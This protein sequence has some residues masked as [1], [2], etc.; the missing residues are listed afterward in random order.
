[1][2]TFVQA[3]YA[4]VTF[5][6]INNISA[7]TDPILTKFFGPNFG[8]PFL[9]QGIFIPKS[10]WP[11]FF[12]TRFSFDLN[13]FS[14]NFFWTKLLLTKVFFGPKFFWTRFFSDL[15]SLYP[16]FS[17]QNF[18]T[19]NLFHSYF[20]TYDYL[21]LKFFSSIKFEGEKTFESKFFSQNFFLLKF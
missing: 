21:D 5:V 10:F 20:W 19:Q 1:M 15:N 7:V 16:Q 9:D 6:Q 12:L 14:P 4:L 17:W 3:R 11:K 2:V 13:F 18:W 8:G